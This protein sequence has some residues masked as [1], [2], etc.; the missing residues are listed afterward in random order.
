MYYAG[1]SRMR[2]RLAQ[3]F[4]PPVAPGRDSS[5]RASRGGVAGL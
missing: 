5:H 3:C 4:P 2:M 1:L